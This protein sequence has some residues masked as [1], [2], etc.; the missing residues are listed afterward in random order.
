MVIAE[1]I[2]EALW[3]RG[4]FGEISTRQQVTVVHCNNQSAIHLTKDQMFQEKKKHIDVRYYFVCDIISKGNILIKKIGVVE[5]PIDMMNKSLV[6][7]K[8]KHCLDLISI[9][10]LKGIVEK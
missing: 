5:N 7:S 3:L 8:F 6:V 9:C 4:L 1:A 10:L 2:K